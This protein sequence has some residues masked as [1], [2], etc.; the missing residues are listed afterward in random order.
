MR[1]AATATGVVMNSNY[2]TTAERISRLTKM[3]DELSPREPETETYA[4]YLTRALSA[5][6]LARN[7]VNERE[8]KVPDQL[9]KDEPR[10]SHREEDRRQQ[11][12]PYL[13]RY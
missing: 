7:P 11:T 6:D 9:D 5:P 3:E 10:A 8:L 1:S 13:G 12:T 2:P 4:K